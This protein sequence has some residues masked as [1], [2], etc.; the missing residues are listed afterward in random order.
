VTFYR[1]QHSIPSNRPS[2][3]TAARSNSTQEEEVD[4][5]SQVEQSH[6]IRDYTKQL[7]KYRKDEMDIANKT[8]GVKVLRR[9]LRKL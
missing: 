5:E 8:D 6:D 7:R 9:L 2:G 1:G 3:P 4:D